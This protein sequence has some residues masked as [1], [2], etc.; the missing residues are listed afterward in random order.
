MSLP[1]TVEQFLGVFARYNEAV[2]PGQL[3]LHLLGVMC[4]A[5]LSLRT[6]L[7]SRLVCAS[8]AFFWA[9]AGVVYHALF[10]SPVN[11]AAPVF[12]ALFIAAA[13]IFAWHGVLHERLRFVLTPSPQAAVGFA[14]VAYA[15]LAYPLLAI[16]F[17]HRYPAMPTF[18]A[19]C[20]ITIFTLGMLAFLRPPYPRHVFVVPL[21]W[22]LVAS[23]ATLF[24]GMYEDLGL[25]AAGAA[26]VWLALQPFTPPRHA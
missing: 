20:P 14:L 18:G 24:L 9:W 22:V 8:L 7:A 16:A 10:F 21:A 26:G 23:Q 19:P 3:S 4:V 1:F 5:A 11:P 25:L 6:E 17:G 12:A 15:L 13:V 2:W